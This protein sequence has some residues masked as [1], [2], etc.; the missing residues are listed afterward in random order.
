[1]TFFGMV[2]NDLY[3]SLVMFFSNMVEL[4]GILI[5]LTGIIRALW[6]I[7]LRTGGGFPHARLVLGS[8]MVLALDFFVGKDIIDTVALRPDNVGYIDLA[9][10]ITVVGVRIVLNHFLLREI[11]TIKKEEVSKKWFRKKETQPQAE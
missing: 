9:T 3:H 7:C 5:I 10:L 2:S 8:H 6:V 11:H 4:S 1:M